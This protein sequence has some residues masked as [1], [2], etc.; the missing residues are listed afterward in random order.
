MPEINQP[1]DVSEA[2]QTKTKS[3]MKYQETESHE[4]FKNY[5]QFGFK[6]QLSSKIWLKPTSNL[7]SQCS[8]KLEFFKDKG[9]VGMY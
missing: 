4:L 7:E 6:H 2:T 5:E 8:A 3:H 1:P 9:K